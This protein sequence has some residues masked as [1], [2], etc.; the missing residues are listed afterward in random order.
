[1]TI[2]YS[3]LPEYE[4]G[5]HIKRHLVIFIVK[6]ISKPTRVSSQGAVLIKYEIVYELPF[7]ALTE[8]FLLCLYFDTN[9]LIYHDNSLCGVKAIH[10]ISGNVHSLR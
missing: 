1:M 8:S 3:N 7:S 2:Q 5:Y 4:K 6:V 10:E 9:I